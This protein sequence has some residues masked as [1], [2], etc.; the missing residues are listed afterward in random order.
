MVSGSYDNTLKVWD[1]NN[2][3]TEIATLTGHTDA[4]GVY[5]SAFS[6]DG[7]VMVSGSSDH[8]LKVWD[9]NNWGT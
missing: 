5:T 8:T 6:P 2:W 3:G 9:A 1:A 7:A 4:Y